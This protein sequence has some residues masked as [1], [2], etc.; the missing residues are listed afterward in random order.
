M[1]KLVLTA[2]LFFGFLGLVF[3]LTFISD[4]MGEAEKPKPGEVGADGKKPIGAPFVFLSSQCKFDPAS[5]DRQN[6]MVRGFYELGESDSALFWFKNRSPREVTITSLGASCT[7]CSRMDVAQVPRGQQGRAVLQPG[8]AASAAST[9]G[10]RVSA[11]R[12][13]SS[14]RSSL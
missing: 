8:R 3:G 6:R 11:K 12:S 13:A 14:L 1:K 2:L 7:T 4:F 10:V 5:S 9:Q